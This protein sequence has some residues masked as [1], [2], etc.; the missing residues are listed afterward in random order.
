MYD[1]KRKLFWAVDTK[2]NVF[3]LRLKPAEA[4]LKAME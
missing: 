3:V 2:S 4:Q 1:S